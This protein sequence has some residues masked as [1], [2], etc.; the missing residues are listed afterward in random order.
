MLNSTRS[1]L[2]VRCSREEADIIR[3]A[4]K[5]ERRTVSGFILNAVLNRIRNQQTLQQSWTRPKDGGGGPS[6]PH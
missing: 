2:L 4:A 5:R 1:A 6:L 3:Q